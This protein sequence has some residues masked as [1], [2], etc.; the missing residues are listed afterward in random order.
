M[1]GGMISKNQVAD[2]QVPQ[3]LCMYRIMAGK[4]LS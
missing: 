4:T 3:E 1:N 2:P